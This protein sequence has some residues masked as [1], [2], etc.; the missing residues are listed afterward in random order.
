MVKKRKIQDGEDKD[1]T[2]PE[3]SE[4]KDNTK[5]HDTEAAEASK[6]GVEEE[7]KAGQ[8]E[9]ETVA[10]EEA[11]KRKD[12]DRVMLEKLAEMQDKYLRLSAEFDNYRKRT[13]KEKMDISK[14]AG[15]EI[16]K[17]ILPIID[18]FDRALKHMESSPDCEGIKEGIDLIYNKFIDY[19]KRQG[20][21]EIESLN[22]VF[23]VDIHDAAAKV[24]VEEEEKKGKV[25]EVLLKG[26]YLKDKVLRHSKVVIGE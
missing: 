10:R 17:D 23:N 16:M 11:D 18:D 5:V 8:S 14:Y 21:K 3:T 2:H 20:I 12:E 25:V 6:Q 1:I 22:E 4:N 7:P 26:Y 13:L 9:P 19:L 24:Q 15:E